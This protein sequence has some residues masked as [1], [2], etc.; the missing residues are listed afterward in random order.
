ML[1][2]QK[3]LR[4]LSRELRPILSQVLI[5]RFS[6]SCCKHDRSRFLLQQIVKTTFRLRMRHGQI[7]VVVAWTMA[8]QIHSLR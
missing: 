4:T 3:L 6:L 7:N 1:R 8:M 5:V 2:E